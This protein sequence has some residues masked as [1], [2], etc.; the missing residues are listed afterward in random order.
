M[1][2]E[3]KASELYDEITNKRDSAYAKVNYHGAEGHAHVIG[4]VDDELRNFF[5]AE[6]LPVARDSDA[7]KRVKMIRPEDVISIEYRDQ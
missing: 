4:V 6:L 2:N 3:T 5:D 1:T 7:G